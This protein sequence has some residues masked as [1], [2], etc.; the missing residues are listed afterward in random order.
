METKAVEKKNIHWTLSITPQVTFKLLITKRKISFTEEGSDELHGNLV[1]KLR[2]IPGTNRLYVPG[3]V[4]QQ[5]GHTALSH[6]LT[7]MFS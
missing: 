1:N 2:S 4:M 5:E 6:V 7:E 3:D